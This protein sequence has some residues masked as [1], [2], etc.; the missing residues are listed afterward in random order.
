MTTHLYQNMISRW[1][2]R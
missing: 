2:S 1:K